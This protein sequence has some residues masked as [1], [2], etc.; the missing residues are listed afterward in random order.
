ML[1]P[2]HA[3]ADAGRPDAPPAAAAA[4]AAEQRQGWLSWAAGWIPWH[5]T[6]QPADRSAFHAAMQADPR[7]GVVL[8]FALPFL[9]LS[10][11]YTPSQEDMDAA[12]QLMEPHLESLRPWEVAGE[13][14]LHP[15]PSFYAHAGACAT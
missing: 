13:L 11:G 1:W 2:G 4:T 15:S 9:S 6:V 8:A 10:F 12:G 14:R 5:G 7:V 3:E